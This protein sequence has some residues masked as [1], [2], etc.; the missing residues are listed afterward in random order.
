MAQ[1]ASE[2]ARPV[3]SV[4]RALALLAELRDSDNNSGLG[5]NELA[6]RIAVNP[7]T[8]SRLLATLESAGFVQ[9]EAQGPY[10]LGLALVGLADRVLESLDIQGLARPVLVELMERTGETATLS[11]PGEHD[12]T[13]V[14]AV[15]SRAS[16]V[17]TAR[18]GRAS[19]SYA[20]AVGKAMLAFGGGPLPE[21]KELKPF[22]ERT[23]T[24][25]AALEAEIDAVR[26]RG[27]A[28]ALGER[29]ADLGAIAAPVFGREGSLA[30]ILGLQG[31]VPRLAD[32]ARVREPLLA[33]AAELTRALGG[34]VHKRVR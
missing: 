32:P 30:A 27:Y 21:Q 28:T 16:V 25:R 10:R 20:T 19:V 26:E 1:R 12:A 9:R 29:E 11:L 17:S 13:T 34:D 18:L 33:G 31:P 24:A 7:S 6:R 3:A 8:A 22:T 2:S 14:D 4:A 15:P 23:I 5:V